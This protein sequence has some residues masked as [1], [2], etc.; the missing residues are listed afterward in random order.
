MTALTTPKCMIRLRKAVNVEILS[1]GRCISR[2]PDPDKHVRSWPRLLKKS[3]WGRVSMS[4]ISMSGRFS[5][6]PQRA[7]EAVF[8]VEMVEPG[9]GT[10]IRLYRYGNR[11][12]V[13]APDGPS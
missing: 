1:D 4:A 11:L 3:D 13:A 7:A 9:F 12:T 10:W 8:D 2:R 6:L 5:F